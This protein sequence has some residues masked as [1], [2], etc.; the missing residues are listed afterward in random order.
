M[1]SPYYNN[2]LLQNDL[3]DDNG[4]IYSNE[5]EIDTVTPKSNLSPMDNKTN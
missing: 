3:S 2:N 4:L 1:H 5:E